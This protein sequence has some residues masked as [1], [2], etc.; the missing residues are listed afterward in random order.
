MLG[1]NRQDTENQT[2]NKTES[3]VLFFSGTCGCGALILFC[4]NSSVI[5]IFGVYYHWMPFFFCC[6]VFPLSYWNI[7]F[8]FV[9]LYIPHAISI[10]VFTIPVLERK[11]NFC[12][13]IWQ[14]SLHYKH[15]T[16]RPRAVGS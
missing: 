10:F 15:E 4:N 5:Q 7:I 9:L 16:W 8:L 14:P 13:S 11:G 12:K 1:K 2:K 6:F 3:I